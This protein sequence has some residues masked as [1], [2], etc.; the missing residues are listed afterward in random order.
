MTSPAS[1]SL[2]RSFLFP[3]LA[4]SPHSALDHPPENLQARS[5]SV[6]WTPR[7]LRTRQSLGHIHIMY[8]TSPTSRVHLMV[9]PLVSVLGNS[10]P[11]SKQQQSL[12]GLSNQERDGKCHPGRAERPVDLL[13]VA[14]LLGWGQQGRLCWGD[15]RVPPHRQCNRKSVAVCEVDTSENN[16]RALF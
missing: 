9:T 10:Y 7:V 4:L 8:V 14:G 5:G 12:R 15:T 6:A 3:G 2:T 13:R 11:S 16:R 1:T